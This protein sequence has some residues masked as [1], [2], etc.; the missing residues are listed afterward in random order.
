MDEQNEQVG[1]VEVEKKIVPTQ[2]KPNQEKRKSESNV[3]RP[4]IDNKG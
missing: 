1:S 3:L 4:G 2:E